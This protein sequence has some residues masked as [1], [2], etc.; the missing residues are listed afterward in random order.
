MTNP[1]ANNPGRLTR[2]L[3]LAGL[4]CCR[5]DRLLNA[6][7]EG[8]IQAARDFIE[9]LALKLTISCGW[10]LRFQLAHLPAAGHRKQRSLLQF[11]RLEWLGRVRLTVGRRVG[12]EDAGEVGRRLGGGQDRQG[13]PP[14]LGEQRQRRHDV[15]DAAGLARPIGTEPVDHRLGW[16]AVVVSKQD[17]ARGRFAGVVFKDVVLDRV[18]RLVEHD[19][20]DG[21]RPQSAEVGCADLVGFDELEVQLHQRRQAG[22]AGQQSEGLAVLGAGHPHRA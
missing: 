19:P 14:Q 3:G 9:Q 8:H 10:L 7:L 12:V 4:G 17:A 21:A 6:Q 13:E 18:A 20:V 22:V 1:P 5:K 2:R 15:R 11:D 16:N